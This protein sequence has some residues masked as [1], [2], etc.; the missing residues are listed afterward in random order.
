MN[1]GRGATSHGL[2]IRMSAMPIAEPVFSRSLSSS[3]SAAL[4]LAWVRS[5]FP[6]LAQTIDQNSNQLPA[7]FLDGPGG[8]QVPQRVI[9]AIA[10]Y[11]ARTNANTGGAYHTSR[12]TDRMIAEARLAMGD[13]LNC[14]ADEI[15][16]GANM[17]SLT[18]A[19]S[20]ALGRELG[21]GDEIV[22][23]LLDHDANFSPWK[24]LEEKGVVIRTVRFNEADCTLDMH[25]LAANI[26]KDTRL[27]AVGHAS[28]AVGTINNV[29]E[30]VRLARQAGALSYI[31]SVH[32]APHGPIDVRAL[33]CDF[34]VCSTY[35][36]FG[37]HMGVLFGKREHLQ[38][39]RPYK[40]RPNTNAIPNCWE[41]GTLNH[42]CI[43]GIAACV[44]YIADLGRRASAGEEGNNEEGNNH[45]G[46][47]EARPVATAM[48]GVSE[49]GVTERR[50][51]IEAAYQAIHEHERGLLDRIMTGLKKI[52]SLKVYGITDTARFDQRCTTLAIR[53]E[54]GE[55]GHPPLELATQLGNRGFF[56][57]DGNYYAL[58]LTEHLDVEKSGGFLRIGLVH[59]NT[60]D[61]VD[62]LLAAL[63]EIVG[64]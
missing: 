61:E 48:R 3:S 53:I 12:N 24:A 4:D 9:D 54:D 30:V 29:A 28:N 56:T 20:R 10:D 26:R 33:D 58:N 18:Y 51:A 32:Y 13:F 17:T 50:A 47:S 27:V 1:G 21:P 43:A 49:T 59:Y 35:K 62:R 40:V 23:T 41:W 63:R 25:D 52:P 2:P 55:P 31:D 22:L 39:L 16:F 36:F 37:P 45:E 60:V 15:V 34:L 42:E 6:S 14:D 11:L 38:R 57:W 46:T 7:A 5:Q 44:D 19:I 8:T 64:M